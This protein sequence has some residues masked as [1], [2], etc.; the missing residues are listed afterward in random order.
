MRNVAFIMITLLLAK[1]GFAQG[2]CPV[3]VPADICAFETKV[4]S[5]LDF[6]NTEQLRSAFTEYKN[7]LIAQSKA[8]SLIQER[9]LTIG[10]QMIA[11]SYKQRAPQ[12]ILA[13]AKGKINLVGSMLDQ[14]KAWESTHGQ[15]VPL[16]WRLPDNLVIG[17]ASLVRS[18]DVATDRVR[19]GISFFAFQK[20]Y[21]QLEEFKIARYGEQ[22]I[23][24]KKAGVGNWNEGGLPAAGFPYFTGQS[25][26]QE[27]PMEDGLYI[28]TIKEKG[29][30]TVNGW[31]TLHG[32]SQTSPSVISPTVNETF[33]TS[34]PTFKLRDF[35]SNLSKASENRKRSLYVASENG[36]KA[37]W[38]HAVID[39]DDDSK[40]K[41]G[42]SAN[43]TGSDLLEPGPYRLN[44]A[45]E[46]RSYFGDLLVGR[47]M[48]TTITFNIAK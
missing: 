23:V 28:L 5:Q 13:L 36:G 39:P 48:N 35:K 14:L 21:H 25:T 4:Y 47:L 45:Y 11:E 26:Y 10:D 6:K 27:T 15:V 42:T 41:V 38:K 31:F 3:S 12:K 8:S 2:P 18:Y 22:P 34:Q 44:V 16:D 24:D 46:E 40:I 32:T 37:T 29:K 30:K 1:V 9:L 17:V 43:A 7:L 20:T 19:Y 33:N